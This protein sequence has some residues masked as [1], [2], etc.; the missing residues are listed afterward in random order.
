MMMHRVRFLSRCGVLLFCALAAHRAAADDDAQAIIGRLQKKYDAIRDAAVNFTEVVR[1]GVTQTEQTFGGKFF[2]KRGNKYRIELE[3]ETIV[4][5]G[6]TVWSFSKLNNQ[7]LIDKYKEDPK[8]FSPDK[9]LVNVPANYIAE[10]LGRDTVASHETDQIK[11][12]PKDTK[13]N[14]KWIK[15]WVDRDELL[16]RKMQIL[17]M[18]DNL[19]T[20]NIGEIRLNRAMSD[21]EFEFQPPKTAEVIDLR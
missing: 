16:M 8:S 6:S 17:D 13:G 11:L 1:F 4:T 21:S 14:V 3:Q 12:V 10:L 7:V 2:M 15:V 20:Y 18:S 19:T 5:D 9:V